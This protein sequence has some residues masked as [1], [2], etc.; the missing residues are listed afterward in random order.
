[1]RPA[2]VS[3]G[4]GNPAILACVGSDGVEFA[5]PSVTPGQVH[6]IERFGAGDCPTFT[7][8]LMRYAA[9]HGLSLRDSRL[10]MSIA[11]AVNGTTMRTTNG[12]WFISMSGLRA[13][14]GGEPVVLNDV[15]ATAWATADCPKAVSFG[16]ALDQA[17]SEKGRHAIISAWRGGLGAACVDRR[18]GFL[19]IIESEAGHT[20]FAVQ[21]EDDWAMAK[22]C[23]ARHGDLSYEYILFDLMDGHSLH[24]PLAGSELEEMFA[25]LLGRYS[26]AVTLTFTAW[27]GI[28]LCGSAFERIA[29]RHLAPVFR[30]A[31]EGKGKLR[32]LL[33][34]TPSQLFQTRN[35]SLSGLS[36]YYNR[37]RNG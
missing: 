34:Q 33:Q 9:V 7:D 10:F 12:R 30:A 2:I 18:D 17:R 31:F 25:T 36:I 5:L 29:S 20:P 28:Y 19:K 1:M 15:A 21:S 35:G 22:A 3:M 6:G 14:T 37:T 23:I 16:S 13:V 8:A 24:R 32:L 11:G 26:A 27:D 4:Q